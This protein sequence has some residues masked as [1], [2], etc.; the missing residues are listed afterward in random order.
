VIA[1]TGARGVLGRA[2][3]PLLPDDTVAIDRRDGI[4]L[5]ARD[6]VRAAL[7]GCDVLVHLAALH[8]LIAPEGADYE[9]ANV[10][11]FAALLDV[12]NAAGVSRVV[13]ASSTSVWRDSP[14]GQP[15]RFLDETSAPDAD[16]GYAR[17][18][19]RCERM[20]ATSGLDGVVLRLARFARDGVAEDEVRKL[21]RA[22][23][24]RDAAAAFV[25]AI[26]R[27]RPESVYAISAPTPFRPEDAPLLDRD[28]AAAIERRTGRLPPWTP[29]RI[30]SVV[31]AERAP[32]EL[33]WECAHPS[34][35]LRGAAASPLA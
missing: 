12:A 14:P 29:P 20:L 8:P 19:R 30:G 35:L 10:T 5:E 1:V 26:A 24:P 21:Y 15:A 34:A 25:K 33:G 3:L 7:E 6:A 11:P 31:V 23:D 4:E 18:K 22:I 32:R 16:D 2:L 13:L 27:G 9:A 28:P 17:S